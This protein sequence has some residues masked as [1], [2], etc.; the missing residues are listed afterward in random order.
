MPRI[1]GGG[2][3]G[4]VRREKRAHE[5]GVGGATTAGGVAGINVDV[6]LGLRT[7]HQ[8][9]RGGQRAD[10]RETGLETNALHK[11]T[12]LSTDTI[13]PSSLEKRSGG[14][15]SETLP[16]VQEQCQTP[17]RIA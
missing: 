13:A 16:G 6:H 17:R 11:T 7:A 5:A 1:P 4:D 3:G 12:N 14:S 10:Q 2:G 8:Q 9:Q 15:L